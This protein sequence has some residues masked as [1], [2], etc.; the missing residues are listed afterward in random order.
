MSLLNYCHCDIC[1]QMSTVGPMSGN[2]IGV[3]LFY[4]VVTSDYCNPSA[5][6][7]YPMFLQVNFPLKE[8]VPVIVISDKA[9]FPHTQSYQCQ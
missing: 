1:P 9:V 2:T 3:S 6:F 8:K 5:S 7:D 4:I